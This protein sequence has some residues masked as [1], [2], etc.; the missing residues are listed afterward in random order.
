MVETI[1]FWFIPS[2]ILMFV[3]AHKVYVNHDR[4]IDSNGNYIKGR[5]QGVATAFF[6]ALVPVLNWFLV[7]ASIYN[8][9]KKLFTRNT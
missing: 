4:L 7:G 1:L 9:I 8:G 2:V 3:I 5:M 6:M